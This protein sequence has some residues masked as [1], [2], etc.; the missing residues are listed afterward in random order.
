LQGGHTACILA[1][2][3]VYGLSQQPTRALPQD[4]GELIVKGSWLSHAAP[5]TCRTRQLPTP[6]IPPCGLNGT[7]QTR[8][9]PC[10][11]GSSQRSSDTYHAAHAAAAQLGNVRVAICNAVV[12]ER[13]CLVEERGPA[14]PRRARRVC[15]YIKEAMSHPARFR[16]VATRHLANDHWVMYGRRPRC[17]R[18]LTI[19]EAFGCGHVFGL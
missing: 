10:A 15:I 16:K 19:S 12:L 3:V 8:S 14:G 7:S 13:S 4:F 5:A 1:E 18:N 17:K 9:P 6:R 2:R 11:E